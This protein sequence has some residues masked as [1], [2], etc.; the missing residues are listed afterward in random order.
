MPP[1][2]FTTFNFKVNLQLEG[3]SSAI[4]AA[5]FSDCDGLEMSL[6]PKTIRDPGTG[7]VSRRWR[8]VAGGRWLKSP[9]HP[10][11]AMSVTYEKARSSC[12]IQ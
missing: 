7:K 10:T 4:C 6:E 8:S 2:P 1:R 5:E 11:F 9:D 3:E 12:K